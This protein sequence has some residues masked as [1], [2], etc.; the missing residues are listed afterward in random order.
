VEGIER[1]QFLQAWRAPGGGTG[2]GTIIAGADGT[3]C[4]T[5]PA[6]DNTTPMTK[7]ATIPN[8]SVRYDDADESSEAHHPGYGSGGPLGLH[9]NAWAVSRLDAASQPYAAPRR[10]TKS[11]TRPR[12]KIATFTRPPAPNGTGGL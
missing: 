3:S 8:A 5:A 11:S 1:P 2:G 7:I 10:P 12:T 4:M 9:V 6:T